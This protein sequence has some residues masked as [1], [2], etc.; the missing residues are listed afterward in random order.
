M[1]IAL[2]TLAALSAIPTQS[3][4]KLASLRWERRVLLVSAPQA[5]DPAADA[6]R[7]IFAELK[8]D[9]DDRD[10]VLVEALGK[11]VRGTSD[12]AA[13]LRRSYKLP[14]NGFTV[15]L[16]GKDGDEK[17]RSAKPIA[18][19]KLTQT[20]DAMPMRRAGER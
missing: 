3:E 9:S 12:T 8:S 13:T 17:L 6:Q 15:I 19:T 14:A 11:A 18:M 16:I 5:G 10:L 20:I 1:S 7:R 4:P 2:I